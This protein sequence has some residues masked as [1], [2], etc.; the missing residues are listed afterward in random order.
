LQEE[1]ARVTQLE[2]DKRK[3]ENEA[4]SNKEAI[5]KLSRDLDRT[6]TELETEKREHTEFR[7]RVADLMGG[8]K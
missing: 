7:A 1:E 8:R 6:K 4:H 3:L 5:D 2:S